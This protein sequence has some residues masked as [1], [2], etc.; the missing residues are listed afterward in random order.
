MAMLNVL[1]M[2]R[3]YQNQWVVLD[4]SLNVVDSG[5]DLQELRARHESR[6]SHYTLYF[7]P[8]DVVLGA[9]SSASGSSSP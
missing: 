3:L 8:G 6:N 9:R 5:A 1:E 2:D 4:R 7:V